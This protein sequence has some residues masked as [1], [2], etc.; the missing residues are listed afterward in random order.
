MGKSRIFCNPFIVYP[1]HSL[2]N[3]CL[4][5]LIDV[6]LVC[7]N[8]NTKFLDVVSTADVDGEECVDDSLV[9]ILR[10]RFCLNF[11]HDSKFELRSKILNLNVGQVSKAEVWSRL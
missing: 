8:A 5:D 7:E 3:S 10:L 9:N 1:C 4:V 2:I 6:T 11:A